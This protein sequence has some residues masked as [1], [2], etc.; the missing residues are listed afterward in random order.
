[1]GLLGFWYHVFLTRFVW[2]LVR[3]GDI[4]RSVVIIAHLARGR[5]SK[6]STAQAL[7][8]SSNL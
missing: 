3:M 4:V 7:L 1:M 2:V 8:A 6:S 5:S